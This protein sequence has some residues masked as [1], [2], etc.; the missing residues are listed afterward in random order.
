MDTVV[1]TSQ[2]AVRCRTV[3]G[4]A[5][6]K[7]IPIGVKLSRHRKQARDERQRA[8]QSVRQWNG[9]RPA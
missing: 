8:E 3:E 4:V 5:I 2:G 7:G 6:F 9:Q 1:R